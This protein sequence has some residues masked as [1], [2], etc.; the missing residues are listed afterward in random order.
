MKLPIL[1]FMILCSISFSPLQGQQAP[2]PSSSKL[3]FLN[4]LYWGGKMIGNVF[5]WGLETF[6]THPSTIQGGKKLGYQFK[7]EVLE[8]VQEAGESILQEAGDSTQVIITS[9]AAILGL[10][11]LSK[12]IWA[13]ID[14]KMKEPAITFSKPSTGIF[15]HVRNWFWPPQKLECRTMCF[16][17]KTRDELMDA[18]RATVETAKAIQAGDQQA[19]YR[20]LFL[21][22]PTGVGKT[23]FAKQ[24][25]YELYNEVG[26]SYIFIDGSFFA[27]S[28]DSDGLKRI[29]LLF[30]RAQECPRGALIFVD[31]AELLLTPRAACGEINSEWHQIITKFLSRLKEPNSKYLV[32]F[33]TN[34]DFVLDEEAKSIVY[35][36]RIELPKED[37]R[38]KI[39]QEFRNTL[40]LDPK[41]NTES[42]IKSVE[43]CLDD[44]KISHIASIL[45][46]VSGRELENIIQII[47]QDARAKEGI[48]TNE[49][50]DRAVEHT[51]KKMLRCSEHDTPMLSTA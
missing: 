23:L 38:V 3:R 33:A 13:R 20:H 47:R 26:M 8:P 22:G 31:H 24:F 10:W 5:A 9:A 51:K 21:S 36:M 34:K 43:Q 45:G 42:F 16:D 28:K 12:F 1:G 6:A 50:V 41:N 37:E 19:R 25:A 17:D 2:E 15:S 18:L 46:N 39:L 32:I 49:I 48:V 30:E 14:Q 11:L 40:L 29:E 4:P 7:Q 27:P 44:D 35:Q